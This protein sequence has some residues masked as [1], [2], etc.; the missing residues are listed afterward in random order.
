MLMTKL[1]RDISSFS[2]SVE[3]KFLQRNLQNTSFDMHLR[4]GIGIVDVWGDYYREA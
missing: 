1:K 4:T 2:G 3:E